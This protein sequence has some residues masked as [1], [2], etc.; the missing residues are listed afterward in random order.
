MGEKEVNVGWTG[1][2]INILVGVEKNWK[3]PF[4]FVHTTEEIERDLIPALDSH[5]LAELYRAILTYSPLS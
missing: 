3:F 2:C 5:T 4:C 1:P